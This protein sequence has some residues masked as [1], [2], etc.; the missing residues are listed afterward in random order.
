M[1]SA[2][3]ST[4]FATFAG[5]AR[6]IVEYVLIATVV[7]LCCISYMLWLHKRYAE[8]ELETEKLKI[9]QIE[10]INKSQQ[11]TIEHLKNIR[12]IDGKSVAA[13]LTTTDSIRKS[14]AKATARLEKLE[15]EN[16]NVSKYLATPVPFEL[17]CQA[18]LCR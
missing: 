14:A 15:N 2:L 18:E 7:I 16:E 8:S 10:Q 6:L 3:F 11:E 17:Q 9:S 5:K 12:E 13:L 4:F 1:F